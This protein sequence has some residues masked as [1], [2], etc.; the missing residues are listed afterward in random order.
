MPSVPAARGCSGTRHQSEGEGFYHT[1]GLLIC[2]LI[3]I[4]YMPHTVLGTL[5]IIS[6]LTPV[7]TCTCR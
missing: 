3:N 6:H 5:P 2:H 4:D 1:L 7:I